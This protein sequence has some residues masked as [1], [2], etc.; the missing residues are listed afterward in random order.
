VTLD[1]AMDVISEVQ[2]YLVGVLYQP[3]DKYK[4]ELVRKACDEAREVLR[5]RAINETPPV[6]VQFSSEAT[7]EEVETA[8]EQIESLSVAICRDCGQEITYHFE[9]PAGDGVLDIEPS[10][11]IEQE[12]ARLRELVKG[13]DWTKTTIPW[14]DDITLDDVLNL[15]KP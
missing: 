14:G 13:L 1:D 7:P 15:L 11:I 8:R 3:D 12:H 5:S 9:C 2:M 10:K 4:A 6:L